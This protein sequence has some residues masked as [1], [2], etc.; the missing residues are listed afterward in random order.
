MSKTTATLTIKNRLK[1]GVKFVSV[2]YLLGLNKL[3]DRIF[4]NLME[5]VKNDVMKYVKVKL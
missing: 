2:L 5:A 4:A 1:I 3:A